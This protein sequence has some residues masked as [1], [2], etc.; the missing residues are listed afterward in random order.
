MEAVRTA[1][2]PSVLACIYTCEAH[3]PL[4]ERFHDSAPGR[5]LRE[6]ANTRVIEVYADPTVE[7]SRLSR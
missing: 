5:V 4:L 6:S 3:R 2:S 1:D 7:A